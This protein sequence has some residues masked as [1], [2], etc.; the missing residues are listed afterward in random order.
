MNKDEFLRHFHLYMP[1]QFHQGASSHLR[2]A[3][4]L[5]A[6][7]EKQGQLHLLFT[8]RAAHLR[9]H[10]SQIS[11]PGG[12]VEPEDTSLWHTACREVNEEVGIDPALLTPIG[13]LPPLSTVSAFHVTPILGFL[14]SPFE[15]IIDS[16][17]VQD[18]FDVPL[19][20]LLNPK[21]MHTQSIKR[22]HKL[23]QVHSIP[24][25]QHFIWGMTAQIIWRMQQQFHPV[26]IFK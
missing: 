22:G 6:L 16:N 5:L 12:K 17:E 4:V 11:F 25:R 3:A 7:F 24:Y 1:P 10:P 8:K 20:F 9:H 15:L 13:Q 19:S 26:G 21:N 14:K 2:Q 23:H 18:V